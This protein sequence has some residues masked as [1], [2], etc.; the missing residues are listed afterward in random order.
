M[1]KKIVVTVLLT[2]LVLFYSTT[3]ISQNPENQNNKKH[4]LMIASYHPSFPTFFEQIEGVKSILDADQFVLDIEFMDSKR[5]Y[6][7][8]NF[9]NFYD[10]L[11]YKINNHVPYDIIIVTDDNALNFMLENHQKLFQDIPVVFC[12]VNSI[13]L[14]VEQNSNQY[15][16]GVLEAVSMKATIEL[17]ISLTANISVIYAIADETPSGK[18]DLR[19]YRSMSN[20]FPD[21]LF[22]ELLLTELS[23]KNLAD[24]LGSL[25]EN[26]SVLL[27][28]AYRDNSGNSLSFEESLAL[29]NKN[30][31]QP[32]YHLWYHGMGSGV[33]GGKLISHFEQGKTAAEIVLQ[34]LSEKSI[35]TI[36]VLVESP[37]RYYFDH[38]E[39]L[40]FKIKRSQLPDNSIIINEAKK[41]LGL[42]ETTI[43]IILISFVILSLISIMLLI[44]TLKLRKLR[45]ELLV[46]DSIVKQ[47]PDGIILFGM[48]LKVKGWYGGAE[49][50]F[51]L[52]SQQAVGCKISELKL[53]ESFR[54]FL[55]IAIAGSIDHQD[56]SDEIKLNRSNGEEV[57]LEFTSS[58]ISDRNGKDLGVIGICKDYTAKKQ[59]N[60]RIRES[61]LLLL[62]IAENYPNSY[63]SII[64]Q[65]YTIGFTSGSE[66]KKNNLDPKQFLG[67]KVE[68]IFG[69]KAPV[70]IEYMRKTFAG[71]E[72]RFE[73]EINDQHQLYHTIPFISDDGTIS[74]ILSVSENIT[75][76]KNYE[77]K[78]KDHLKKSEKQRKANLVIL[79]DLNEST[80][81]L[82]IE[83]SE[84]KKAEERLN[85]RMKEL[86]IFNEAAVDREIKINDMRQEVNDLLEKLGENKKYEIIT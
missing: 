50:I 45:W 77:M 65:D 51:E 79:K 13:T 52:S 67:L 11:A 44:Y 25:E 16:T 81:K 8:E 33:L 80:R 1:I 40:K 22:K 74:K 15:I 3:L 29:I 68:Q 17:M 39:M 6:D 60:M 54:S 26:S 7:A 62:K 28:S 43:Y 53:A 32:L 34:I 75:A 49:Q 37:N 64:E 4:V 19:K 84:R 30:L 24:K 10:L 56:C 47:F 76:Q 85:V 61:E 71:D 41:F 69:E 42:K 48:D 20:E 55:E 14:A 83:I 38:N 12:G 9:Q 31:N 78:I 35:E 27:L 70:V 58:L 21:I 72:Q 59:A 57:M 23:Y 63:L 46:S 36:P 2:Y 73:L 18:S 86:E 66:F 5:F 82:K